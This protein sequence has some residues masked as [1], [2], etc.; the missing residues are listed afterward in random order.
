MGLLTE[1]ESFRGSGMSNKTYKVSPIVVVCA[2]ALLVA[3]ASLTTNYFFG[4][5]A[6]VIDPRVEMEAGGYTEIKVLRER[7][8][9]QRNVAA[10]MGGEVAR[11]VDRLGEA[12]ALALAASLYAAT[13]QIKGRTPKSANDLLTGVASQNLLPPG[14]SLTQTEGAL[15]SSGG[16]LYLRYRPK[17]LAIEVVAIAREQRDG[18]AILV[19]IPDENAKEGGASLF[20]ATR[21]SDVSVPQAFA[22]A[23]EVIAAGWSPEPLRPINASITK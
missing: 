1:W 14:L 9:R 19:R 22:P 3:T 8:L 4:R 17:P 2:T 16:T 6:R 10:V 23:A 13:E 11:T 20:L 15:A 5:S 7:T 18:P 21:L 12:E